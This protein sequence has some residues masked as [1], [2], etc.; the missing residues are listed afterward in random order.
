MGSTI[1]KYELE[2]STAWWNGQEATACPYREGSTRRESWL[3]GHRI[4]S[5]APDQSHRKGG[6]AKPAPVIASN[7]FD[8]RLA[9]SMQTIEKIMAAAG[10]PM[11]KP[12]TWK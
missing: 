10:M 3:R 6:K 7:A 2:G 12:E 4:A 9:Q 8:Q 5:R 1:S 11:D